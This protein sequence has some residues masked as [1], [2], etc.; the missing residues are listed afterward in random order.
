[1][2]VASGVAGTVIEGSHSWLLADPD[3]FGE[4]IT[5]DM[6]VAQA[7]RELESQ[8]P[9]DKRRGIRRVP[10]L[11]KR[12]ESPVPIVDGGVSADATAAQIELDGDGT[13]V[14]TAA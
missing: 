14:S 5:N 13:A 12:R 10:T 7:A 8:A 3:Q 1:L 9:P 2:C 6:R 4:V 11:R